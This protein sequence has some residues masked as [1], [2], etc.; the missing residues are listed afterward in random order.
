MSGFDVLFKSQQQMQQTR[1]GYDKM[2]Y[3]MEQQLGQTLGQLPQNYL[4]GAKAASDLRIQEQ[5]AEISA[6][7]SKM[8]LSNML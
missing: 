6:M 4:A 7:Q 3:G 2:R 1:L 8:Q 5:Q